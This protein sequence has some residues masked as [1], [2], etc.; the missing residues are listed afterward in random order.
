MRI[1]DKTCSYRATNMAPGVRG[2]STEG[3]GELLPY[4]QGRNRLRAVVGVL[5]GDFSRGGMGCRQDALFP[6][7]LRLV[8]GPAGCD[9]L[10]PSSPAGPPLRLFFLGVGGWS[11]PHRSVLSEEV[12]RPIRSSAANHSNEV[13]SGQEMFVPGYERGSPVSDGLSAEGRGK[14]FPYYK[15]RNR[16]R[17]V[18]GA[19][20]GV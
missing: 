14:L 2:L 10:R 6:L 4:Y 19:L 7:R 3:R 9:G 20:G 1:P 18:V 5:S 13:D 12:G 15:G 11:R 17:T 8:T 16:L